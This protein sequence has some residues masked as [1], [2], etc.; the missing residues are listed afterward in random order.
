MSSEDQKGAA[1]E[2]RVDTLCNQLNIPNSVECLRVAA[3]SAQI[4]LKSTLYK[5]PGDYYS[6]SL[7]ERR[8][9]LHSSTTNA[10]CK[11]LIFENTYWKP[12]SECGEECSGTDPET[13]DADYSRYYVC[14]VQYNRKISDHKLFKMLRAKRPE[15]SKKYFNFR[16]AE[17][18]DALAGFPFNGVAPVGMLRDIPIIVSDAIMEEKYM[19]MGGGL[20]DVKLGCRPTDLVD[21]YQWVDPKTMEVSGAGGRIMVA[22]VTVD[23]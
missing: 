13:G 10:L 20:E 17:D 6:R 4:G 15:L 19:F 1:I 22:D 16:C 8:D 12:P 3:C 2:K 7:E 18:G 5:V 11:S 14:L 23:E 21:K 9:L